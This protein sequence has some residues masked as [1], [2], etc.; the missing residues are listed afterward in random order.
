MPPLITQLVITAQ[1][2]CLHQIRCKRKCIASLGSLKAPSVWDQVQAAFLAGLAVVLLLIPLNR[3]L[4]LRIE[5]ASSSMMGHKDARI[6]ATSELLRGIRQIK[7][8]SWEP[9]FLAQVGRCCEDPSAVV[10]HAASL[11]AS[12]NK[13]S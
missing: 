8:A 3:W 5:A 11:A 4:A 13:A 7:A 10:R 1:Q 6:K 2:Q 12:A 9:A